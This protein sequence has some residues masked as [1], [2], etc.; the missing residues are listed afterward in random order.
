[1]SLLLSWSLSA[2]PSV[3][4]LFEARSSAYRAVQWVLQQQQADGSWSQDSQ[5]TALSISAL[6][7]SGY[8]KNDKVKDAIARAVAW[9]QKTPEK[10]AVQTPTKWEL[11]QQRA[12]ALYA[13]EAN[14]I[15]LPKSAANWRSKLLSGLL[16]AQRGNGCWQEKDKDSEAA[17]IHALL[18]L[19]IAGGERLRRVP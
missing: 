18:A 15:P 8:A 13:C 2:A 6:A 14:N 10:P 11:Q 3:S 19:S 17:T 4:L 5:L 16:D 1:V 9:L 7:D 12:R